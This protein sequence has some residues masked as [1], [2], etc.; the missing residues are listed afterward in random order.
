MSILRKSHW[1]ILIALGFAVLAGIVMKKAGADHPV[2]RAMAGACAF[3]GTFFMNALKMIIVPLVATSIIC[4]ISTVGSA[5]G[6]FRLGAKTVAFY[7][8]TTLVAVLT[9]LLLVNTLK[10]GTVDGRPNEALRTAIA[11]QAGRLAESGESART[12]S[13]VEK[14]RA[15]GLGPVAEIFLRMVPPNVVQ[16]AAE[17]QILGLIIFSLLAGIALAL[18]DHPSVTTVRSFIEGLNH[19]MMKITHWVMAIA[20][21]GVFGLVAPVVARAGGEIFVQLARYFVTVVSALGIHMFITL[22]LA[23]LLIGRVKPWRHFAA[24]R[25]ALVTAFSTASSSATLPTTLG[26]L[27]ENAGVSRRIASFTVPLGATVNMDGTALYE[28]VAV[29]FVTQVLGIQLDFAAQLSVVLLA[30]MTSIGVAGVPSASLVAIVIIF[31]SLKIEGIEAAIAVLFSVDR[32]LD[33]SRTAVN[34]FGDSCAAVVI[35]RSEGESQVLA[36]PID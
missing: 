3:A 29:I 33:M 8:L 20:P 26:C 25:D 24:M 13:T 27:Q 7:A 10:P 28:C 6:F 2:T 16:A 35:A 17:D 11:E 9:G 31:Q 19:V 18:L 30:L 5:T 14:A 34:V 15:E 36:D 21:I 4:G 12:L 22:P 1:Q 23:L 32:L